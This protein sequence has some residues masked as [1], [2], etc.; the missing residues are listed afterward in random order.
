ML[1]TVACIKESLRKHNTD[2]VAETRA[3]AILVEDLAIV[4]RDALME[5]IQS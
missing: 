4:L 2:V 5:R 1:Q 3:L